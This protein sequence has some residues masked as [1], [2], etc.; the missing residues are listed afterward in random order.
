MYAIWKYYIFLYC[1]LEKISLTDV[2]YI[3][4]RGWISK[5]LDNVA[6]QNGIKIIKVVNFSVGLP[7]GNLKI[8]PHFMCICVTFKK[9]A[10]KRIQVEAILTKCVSGF[11]FLCTT[12]NVDM[13]YSS[14]H[15][16]S[17]IQPSVNFIHTLYTRQTQH[18]LLFHTY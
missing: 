1:N 12:D 15:Y 10:K 11:S 7:I 16:A 18:P 17:F 9:L 13:V 3:W 14:N 2:D 8:V 4:Q 5:H 6:F